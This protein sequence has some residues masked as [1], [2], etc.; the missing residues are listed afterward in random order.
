MTYSLFRLLELSG[1]L[2]L[3]EALTPQQAAAVFTSHGAEPAKMGDPAYLKQFRLA[4]NKKNHPDAGGDGTA[5]AE[6]NAAY[7]VIKDGFSGSADARTPSG[8]DMTQG[9]RD[10]M[11]SKMAGDRPPAPKRTWPTG[12]SA[13]RNER[14]VSHLY[15]YT[16]PAATKGL[17]GGTNPRQA[18]PLEHLEDITGTIETIEARINAYIKN[19]DLQKS[20]IILA[21]E[22]GW[23]SAEVLFVGGHFYNHP[24]VIAR[25]SDAPLD[26]DADFAAKLPGYIAA[27]RRYVSWHS[28]DR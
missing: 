4:V 25:K 7:D 12:Q 5:A 20:D 17:P 27:I 13:R 8:A 23:S 18:P 9:G 26:Q 28:V 6:V 15:V 14:T 11:R 21:V 10:W 24:Q 1:R 3:A 19:G 2:K 16:A 22:E